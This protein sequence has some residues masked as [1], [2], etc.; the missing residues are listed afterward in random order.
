MEAGMTHRPLALLFPFLLA[1]CGSSTPSSTSSTSAPPTP[2]APA[3]TPVATQAAAPTVVSAA[4]TPK[5]AP[6]KQAEKLALKRLVLAHGIDN[7]E[8]QDVSTSFNAKESRVYAFVEVENP[9]KLPGEVTVEFEPPK[10]KAQGEVKLAVGEGARW[11]TWAF[12]RQ[13]HEPGEW[14]A[15]V[16]DSKGHELGRQTFNVEL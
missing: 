16:R 8:P 7:K 12:T 9:E 15:I 2:A 3:A 10:G 5:P 1:A 14:T 4:P 13:A 6:V 11:R